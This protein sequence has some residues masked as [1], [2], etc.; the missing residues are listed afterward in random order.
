LSAQPAP[1]K[2][3]GPQLEALQK[4]DYVTI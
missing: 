4:L 1:G 2:Y 3:A